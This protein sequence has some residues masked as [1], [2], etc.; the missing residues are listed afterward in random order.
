MNFVIV[1]K[2]FTFQLIVNITI[3]VNSQREL[4]RIKIV[5]PWKDQIQSLRAR[6][7]H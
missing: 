3:Y 1:Y 7:Y 4:R 2:I 5:H 6:Y